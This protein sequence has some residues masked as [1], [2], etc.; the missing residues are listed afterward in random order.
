LTK[1]NFSML[2]LIAISLVLVIALVVGCAAPTTTPTTPTTTTVVKPAKFTLY[3]I[4][5]L[6]GPSAV[7]AA[8][9]H[10]AA[11][12]MTEWINTNKGGIRGVPIE[13]IGMDNAYKVDNT[14]SIYSK[15]KDAK[16][17]PSIMW[18]MASADTEALKDRVNEDK[19][20]NWVQGNTPFGVYPAGGY[21]IACV[22]SYVDMIGGFLTWVTDDWSKKT[23]AP[24]K[25][26]I[27]TW[28][29]TTGKAILVPA[30]REYAKS[31]GIEIVGEELFNPTDLDVSTQLTKLK[32]AGANWI[33]DNGLS[34]T[35]IIINKGMET[36]GVMN[37]KLYDATPGTMHHCTNQNQQSVA[38]ITPAS[39][40]SEGM[41]GTGWAA[42]VTESFPGCKIAVEYADKN[43][44]SN[45]ARNASFMCGFTQLDNMAEFVGLTVDKVGWDKV[46]G[47]TVKDTILGLQNWKGPNTGTYV[48]SYSVKKPE[49][50]RGRIFL[51]TNGKFDFM[52]DF[53]TLPNLA[54]VEFR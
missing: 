11:G 19:I 37:H 20:V 47:T 39:A 1:R 15:F 7:G 17:L 50:N 38:M 33:Y 12:F 21:T 18:T 46:N 10:M 5:D 31:K 8:P 26:G 51:W 14:V 34:T 52:T 41:I 30:M 54:P 4:P 29:Q 36:M 53:F 16:P 32:A 24:V 35:S 2:S 13:Y 25:L 23:G 6:S 9:Q 44:L 42:E 40:A 28:N 48:Y 27:L 22:P 3:A 49:P 43:K 45:P